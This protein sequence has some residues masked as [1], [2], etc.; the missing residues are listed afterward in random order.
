MFTSRS[1]GDLKEHEHSYEHS[2]ASLSSTQ[3]VYVI[4]VYTMWMLLSIKNKRMAVDENEWLIK[5]NG[6]VRRYLLVESL[7]L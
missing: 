5:K 4:F 7:S 2:I 6:A 1:T 3:Y